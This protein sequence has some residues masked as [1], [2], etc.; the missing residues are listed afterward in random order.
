MAYATTNPPKQMV[1]G[2]G[3]GQPSL[4]VYTSTDIHTDVDAADYFS[5]G[6]DLG[7]R[8]GDV[9]FVSKSDATIGTTIHYVSAVTAG[10]AATVAGAI[11]A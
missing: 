3:S 9:M 2:M 1:T 4:W 7:M 5:N 11:L 8:V 10:G 6:D